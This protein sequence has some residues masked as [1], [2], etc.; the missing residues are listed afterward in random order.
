V[1]VF[2]KKNELV[3]RLRR[4]FND[5]SKG[6][7]CALPFEGVV[8]LLDAAFEEGVKAMREWNDYIAWRSGR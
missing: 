2:E 8:E 5:G 6:T 1:I 3:D 4:M 7:L